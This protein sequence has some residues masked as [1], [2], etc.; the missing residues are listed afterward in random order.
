VTTD[1]RSASAHGT[2][3][4]EGQEGTIRFERVLAHPVDRVWTAITT[5]KGLADWWLPFP[6]DIDID[7][8]V[9]GLIAFSAPEFGPASMTCTILELDPPTRLVHTHFDPA[10][11]LSWEL[12]PE[13]DGCRL[14]LT[15]HT[16]DIAAALGQGHIVGLHHSLDRLEPAIDGHPA[17]WDWD[18]LPV[19]E[20]EYRERLGDLMPSTA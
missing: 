16:P 10:V 5:P 8:Q 2:V 11:T 15:Q 9:G 18:R 13:G 4:R 19:L 17:A 7:L 6:A 1:S 12:Q 20:A 14:R 3:D